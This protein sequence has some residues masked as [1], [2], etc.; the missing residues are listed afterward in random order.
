MIAA[1]EIKT[2]VLLEPS[3]RGKLQ[4][5]GSHLEALL[6][7]LQ[8]SVPVV[9]GRDVQILALRDLPSKKG[10]S[11]R[12]GQARLVHDLASIELQAMELGIR[13]LI[14]FPDA[15]RDFREQLAEVTFEEGKHLRLCLDALENIGLPWGS[16]PTHVTLW[17]AVDRSDSLLDRILIVHRYLEGSGLDATDTILRRLSGVRAEAATSAIEVI[18]RDEVGHVLFGSRWYHKILSQQNIS[19]AEDFEPRL[20]RLFKNIPRRI[21]PIR[22]DLRLA[23][24]FLESEID[25]LER[26]RN[27]W[28]K[29]G[30]FRIHA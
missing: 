5:L 18:R 24:G 30:G 4:H 12:E 1:P 8:V 11:T 6:N 7:G 10:L 26:I 22:R 17:F 27:Q 2:Q 21:E 29:P 20:L 14:E 23:A 15:P 13:T 9:P 16:F 19:S 3:V 28:L 25:T